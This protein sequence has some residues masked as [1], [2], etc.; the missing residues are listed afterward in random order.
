[1]TNL[2]QDPKSFTS[3]SSP[4]SKLVLLVTI[5]T[6]GVA[7][8][9]GTAMSI[10]L[11]II[12]IQFAASIS[13]L[14]WALNIYTLMLGI[15][16]LIAG[17]LTDLLS[18]KKILLVGLAVFSVSSLLLAFAPSIEIFIS[19]RAIQGI[20]A[21]LII[22]Q[23]LA[24]INS[25][26][27]R[28]IR[29]WII[30]LW[31]GFTGVLSI[32][33]PVIAGSM[34]D[35]WGWPSIFWAMVPF[36]LGA[37]ALTWY[38]VKDPAYPDKFSWRKF[39]LLGSLVIFVAMSLVSY[40]LI[41]GSEHG[42]GQLANLGPLVIGTMLLLAFW[43]IERKH[44]QPLIRPDI[45]SKHII[46][47]NLFTFLLYGTMGGL[48][49]Y[50]IMNLQQVQGMTATQ[51]SLA[52]LPTM[53]LVTIL[54][55]VT[56]KLAD[57]IGNKWPTVIGGGLVALGSAWLYRVDIGF[58]IWLDLLPG[59]VL[60]G[61][62]FGLFVPALTKE[63][64]DVSFS[65]SGAASGLNNAVARFTPLLTIALFSFFIFSSF[66]TA[67]INSPEY[68]QASPASQ[69]QLA[70][71]SQKLFALTT[72][73]DVSTSQLR[74]SMRQGFINGFQRMTLVAAG[75]SLLGAAIALVTFQNKED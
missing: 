19:L 73:A 47:A 55:F 64:M 75:A 6:S 3:L 42:F 21:A 14:Q 48:F 67:I 54:T 36:G 18:R 49:I 59:L 5:L 69:Q 60:L 2:D 22:P 56:G 53:A 23:G 24:I 37:M 8:F 61:L 62:G 50:L 1:M 43:Q 34:I 68:Q 11:P 41:Q 25:N 30:G 71:E 52:L 66:K 17:A 29:G 27:T 15:F 31:G 46:G 33:A 10:A 40:G 35:Q 9:A 12:Q 16:I 74:P 7:M 4:I 39:D 28:K 70:N 45:L 32:V 63:A 51:A 72:P 58:N 20:G 13:Q 44:S 26:F 57:A 38:V 65:R